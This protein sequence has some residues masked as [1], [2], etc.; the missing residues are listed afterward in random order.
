MKAFKVTYSHG[1]FIDKET[2]KR[3]MP[4]QGEEYIITAY[5]DSFSIED[6]NSLDS[7]VLNSIE[8]KKYVE[9]KY[10]INNVGCILNLGSTLYFKFGNRKIIKGDE[11]NS[12]LFSCVLL[13]DLYI[14]KISKRNP[15]DTDSWRLVDCKCVLEK[16]IEGNLTFTEKIESNSLNT[17]FN[18]TVMFYFPRQR[19]GTCN[20]F[21]TF[22]LQEEN[23][24]NMY[25]NNHVTNLNDLRIKWIRNNILKSKET[26]QNF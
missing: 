8:K 9:D 11:S 13:E 22:T 3:I 24:K 10:G 23:K 16:C 14:Y 4:I 2:K 6:N 17:L 1:H 21:S 25:S 20:A 7:K 18:D 15:T 26:S 5:E 12:F 19:T